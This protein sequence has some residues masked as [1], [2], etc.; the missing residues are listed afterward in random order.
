MQFDLKLRL[1]FQKEGDGV[2]K[3]PGVMELQL[4]FPVCDY[5]E[6]V[7][8][9]LL[10]DRKSVPHVVGEMHIEFLFLDIVLL[11]ITDDGTMLFKINL[12][13]GQNGTDGVEN[14]VIGPVGTVTEKPTF[15]KLLRRQIAVL[16]LFKPIIRKGDM[17]IVRQRPAPPL[18]GYSCKKAGYPSI[19]KTFRNP[20]GA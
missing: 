18:E 17:R 14:R 9:A 15:E 12:V 10:T 19:Y 11:K 3:L 20:E 2:K 8:I 7:I 13:Q 5:K 6:I 16:R 4:H 1:L